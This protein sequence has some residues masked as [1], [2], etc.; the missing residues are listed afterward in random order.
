[1][2]ADDEEGASMKIYAAIGHF[3]GDK[4]IRSIVL[5]QNTRKDLMRDCV[6]NSF[7][8]Y[9]VLTEA[10]AEKLLSC[11]TSMDVFEQVKKLTTNYR[12]WN[13]VTD[14]I[15]EAGYLITERI[16]ELIKNSNRA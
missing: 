9:V 3:K 4:N 2:T 1:M 10:M 16:E 13:E 6:G 8:A 7:V 15:T 5:T 14:Y 12:V 11:E